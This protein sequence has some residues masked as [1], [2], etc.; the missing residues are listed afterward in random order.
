MK[1]FCSLFIFF[2]VVPFSF[3]L[4]TFKEISK[5]LD[6]LWE[7]QSFSVSNFSIF[8]E[9]ELEKIKN[10]LLKAKKEKKLN[11]VFFQ[12]KQILFD[13]SKEIFCSD[14]NINEQYCSKYSLKKANYI[15]G[16]NIFSTLSRYIKVPVNIQPKKTSYMFNLTTSCEGIFS[17]FFFLPIDRIIIFS[18]QGV[19]F[20]F[21]KKI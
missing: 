17:Q 3:S 14:L 10:S 16:N 4:L 8:S 20:V 5:E 12:K 11:V 9:A 2:V 6:G 19:L 13:C 15:A 1:V 7:L 18:I 21:T